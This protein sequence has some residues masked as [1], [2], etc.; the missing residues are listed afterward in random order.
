MDLASPQTSP[1]QPGPH[2]F[3]GGEAGE[4]DDGPPGIG[5]QPAQPEDP[6]VATIHA[7]E[8]A[9]QQIDG[10]DKG[11]EL[12]REQD[13]GNGITRASLRRPAASWPAPRSIPGAPFRLPSGQLKVVPGAPHEYCGNR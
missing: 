4:S 5:D 2:P 9:A 10:H 12:D 3:H 6:P 7:A 8:A 13:A 1:F 11:I